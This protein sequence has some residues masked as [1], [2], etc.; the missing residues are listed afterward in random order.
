MIR[1]FLSEK[2]GNF[3]MMTALLMV[4]LIAVAGLGL[5]YTSA[6]LKKE[7][8]QH[9]ADSAVLLAASSTTSDTEELKAVISKAFL[10]SVPADSDATIEIHSIDV[11]TSG[12]I[13]IDATAE[14]PLSMMKVVGQSSMKVNIFSQS[15]RGSGDD[16]EIALVLDNTGSMAGQKLT[17]LKLASR[18]LVKTFEGDSKAKDKTK[19]SVVPFATYVNVGL[20]NRTATWLTNTKNYDEKSCYTHWPVTGYTNCRTATYTDYKTNTCHDEERVGYSDGFP[21][22]YNER[23]CVKS[24]PYEVEYQSCD[25]VY[26]PGEERCSTASHYWNGC[27]G[28]READYDTRAG[29]AEKPWP[30]IMD[31]WCG[32]PLLPLTNKYSAVYDKIARM[33]AQY[34][35]Y[36][37][38]GVLWGWETLSPEAPFSEGAPYASKVRKFMI[39][40]TDGINTLS[41][42]PGQPYHQGNDVETANARTLLTCTNAKEKGITIFTIGVGIASTSTE[43]MLAKCASEGSMAYSLADSAALREIFKKI[44]KEIMKPR[45]SM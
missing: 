14:I 11:D 25:T 42:S 16:V 36:I 17:D 12:R 39:I 30:G 23:V 38:P 27:V 1:K 28:S 43:A 5:D 26:G 40:M 15:M 4:P 24:D 44:G 31:I 13:S 32:Q 19:F 41:R 22:T 8:L 37:Q 7:D 45:L 35:T 21:Y 9:A 10:A 2:D 29:F 20:G 34:D 33:S 3:G 18:D 6:V